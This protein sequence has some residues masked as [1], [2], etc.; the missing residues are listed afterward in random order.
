MKFR[1]GFVSNSSSM[2]YLTYIHHDR[3]M[4]KGMSKNE[5]IDNLKEWF[6]LQL[7]RGLLEE[8]SPDNYE[9]ADRYDKKEIMDNYQQLQ[10]H[11]KE[12]D[13]LI[14]RGYEAV[15]VIVGWGDEGDGTDPYEGMGTGGFLIYG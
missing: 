12:F 2:S 9:K 11:L 4:A 3:Y 6:D 10:E 15:Q 1:W 8:K 14:E 7:P 5:F 13:R